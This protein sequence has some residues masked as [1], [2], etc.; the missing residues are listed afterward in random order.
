MINKEDWDAWKAN[1][2][3]KQVFKAMKE[4]ERDAIE[5]LL[6]GES[7]ALRGFI[8]AYREMQEMSFEEMINDLNS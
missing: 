4:R 5:E 6:N 8:A 2:V 3:T 7:P 1:I